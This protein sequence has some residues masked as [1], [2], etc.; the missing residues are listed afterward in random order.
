M[1]DHWITKHTLLQ[2]ANNPNDEEAWNDFVGYY[3]GFIHAVLRQMSFDPKDTED[4]TQ[5]ILLKIWRKLSTF[6][7]EKH[8]VHF[9]TWL[10]RLIRNQAIDF[11]KKK[12]GYLKRRDQAEELQTDKL[13][14]TQTDLDQ[15]VDQEWIRHMTNTALDNISELFSGAAVQAFELSLEGIQ[16]KEI[17][18]ELKI[19]P[20]SV[21]TLKNR[22]KQRLMKEIALLKEEMEF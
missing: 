9:R 8:Q 13:I 18:R 6:D 10:S 11:I 2:R 5:E 1:T 17:A 12:Q 15:L 3:M 7:G 19:S 20:D 16:S 4:I 21:R 22:V 14:I